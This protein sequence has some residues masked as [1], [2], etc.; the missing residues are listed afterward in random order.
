[1]FFFRF[2]GMDDSLWFARSGGSFPFATPLA[3]KIRG[4]KRDPED[5]P[6]SGRSAASEAPP[7]NKRGPGVRPE[8]SC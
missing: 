2:F 1:M 4:R 5:P 8:A 7:K 3:I 6:E